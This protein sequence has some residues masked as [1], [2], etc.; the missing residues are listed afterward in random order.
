MLLSAEDYR[1]INFLSLNGGEKKKVVHVENVDLIYSS[2][3]K[4]KART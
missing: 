3:L 2:V 1:L 4:A